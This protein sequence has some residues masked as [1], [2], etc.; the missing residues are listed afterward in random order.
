MKCRSQI[1]WTTTLCHAGPR[2]KLFKSCITVFRH[3]IPA[4]LFLLPYLVHNVVA[5][6][7]DAARQGVQQVGHARLVHM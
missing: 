4:S 7:S 6:G 5:F 3:D 2:V 1:S